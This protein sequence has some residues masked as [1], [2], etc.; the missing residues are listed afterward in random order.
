MSVNKKYFLLSFNHKDTIM[1]SNIDGNKAILLELC[2]I[3][4]KMIH[5]RDHNLK[6]YKMIDTDSKYDNMH[7]N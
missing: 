6:F 1:I 7:I 4:P 5:F 3:I 2:T